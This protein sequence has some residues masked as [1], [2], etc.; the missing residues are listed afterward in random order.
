[1]IQHGLTEAACYRYYKPTT[2]SLDLEDFGINTQEYMNIDMSH[3]PNYRRQKKAGTLSKDRMRASSTSKIDVTDT[4]DESGRSQDNESGRSQDNL[5]TNVNRGHNMLAEDLT[6]DTESDMMNSAARASVTRRSHMGDRHIH[7]DNGNSAMADDRTDMDSLSPMRFELTSRQQKQEQ[8]QEQ[9]T[10]A[11]TPLCNSNKK[12]TRHSFAV[13]SNAAYTLSRNNPVSSSCSAFDEAKRRPYRYPL[14]AKLKEEDEQEKP[15]LDWDRLSAHSNYSSES[16]DINSRINAYFDTLSK[17]HTEQEVEDTDTATSSSCSASLNSLD[18]A[19]SRDTRTS[20]HL[21]EWSV[22]SS[23]IT[24]SSQSSLDVTSD[25]NDMFPTVKVLEDELLEM[26]DNELYGPY[27]DTKRVSLPTINT[28]SRTSQSL[29]KSLSNAPRNSRGVD[30]M[31][32][33]DVEE[34]DTPSSSVRDSME[35][36]RDDGDPRVSI[37]DDF[38]VLPG[39]PPDAELDCDKFGF[40]LALFGKVGRTDLSNPVLY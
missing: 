19:S 26:I 25:S 39:T 3:V 14:N 9:D 4:T 40:P 36:D 35:V 29:S 31:Q 2:P 1:M 16:A 7:F 12:L 18:M 34:A 24:V 8:E 10:T 21:S 27:F 38:V 20:S 6:R 33:R 15:S 28:L 23:D 11:A 32:V 13:K 30:S 17:K 22:I 37:T 5:N